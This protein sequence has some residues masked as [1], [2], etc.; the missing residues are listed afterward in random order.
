MGCDIHL[1]V[2]RR[3]DAGWEHVP[4]HSDEWADP[5]N[6]YHQRNYDLF[7]ILADVR[8]GSGFAGAKIGD[9]FNPIS[10]PR[11]LPNDVSDFVRSESDEW[12]VDGHSHSHLTVAE[13]LTYDWDQESVKTGLFDD[14][15]DRWPNGG[16]AA[17]VQ[18]FA[19]DYKCLPSTVGEWCAAA[20][21]PRADQYKRVT[22][23]TTYWHCTTPE[24]WATVARAAR[25]SKGALDDVRF[26]FWFDN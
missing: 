2:E 24:W 4:G 13:V 19:D 14:R 3:T 26:V 9:G 23:T 10:P 15:G 5:A 6:W 20:S 17:W 16:R 1:H 8:N 12:D 22:W 7:A 21:G 25:L 11:G 18:S